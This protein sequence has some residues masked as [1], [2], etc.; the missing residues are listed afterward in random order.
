MNRFIDH[1]QGVTTN[2]YNTIADLHITNHST[3]SLFSLFP[4][5]ITW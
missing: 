3:Q 4:L 2:N 5:V 1:S